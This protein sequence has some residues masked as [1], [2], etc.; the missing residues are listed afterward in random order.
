MQRLQA[1]QA[2]AA[3]GRCKRMRAHEEGMSSAQVKEED[4]EIKGGWDC[5]QGLPP[6]A[7]FF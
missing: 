5:D 4:S 7:M 2:S 1:T 6:V 3:A